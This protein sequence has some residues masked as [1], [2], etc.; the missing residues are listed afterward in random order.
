MAGVPAALVNHEVTWMKARRGMA[1]KDSVSEPL[2]I[3]IFRLS[4][5]EEGVSAF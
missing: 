4:H 1:F 5:E 3:L 2:H